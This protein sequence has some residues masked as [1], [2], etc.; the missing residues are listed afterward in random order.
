MTYSIWLAP[1][2][3]D[4]KYLNQII[5][6]LSK[7]YDAPKFG[8]H[9]TLYS[10]IRSLTKA[11]HILVENKFG[12][13]RTKSTGIGQSDYLWKTMF[14]KVKK[15]KPLHHINQVLA[16]SLKTKYSFEPH[17]SLIYKK[18]DHQT[19]TKLIKNLKVK[20]SYTFDRIMIVRSSKNVKQWKNLYS[21][22]LD[23]TRRA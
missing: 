8:A 13:I 3:K 21:M 22:R 10:R 5:K 11:K 18:M 16:K 1:T 6:N 4:A 7:Q 20:K 19:K 2:T 12:I 17:I 9:I 15:D 23:S 14:I